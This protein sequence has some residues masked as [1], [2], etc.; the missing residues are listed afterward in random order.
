MAGPSATQLDLLAT[1]VSES[2]RRRT[3]QLAGSFAYQEG[4]RPKL[5]ELVGMGSVA[6]KLYL[7]LVMATRREPH[8]LYRGTSAARFARTLG[9]D[10]GELD[11]PRSAGTRRVQRAIHALHGKSFIVRTPRPGRVDQIEVRHFPVQEP[12]YVT[13]PLDLWRNGWICV[14]SVRALAVYVCLRRHC[15]GNEDEG[16]HVTP[17]VRRRAYQ[18]A[19]DTWTGG[20]EDLELAGLLTRTKGNPADRNAPS[21]R[22]SIYTLHSDRMARPPEAPSVASDRPEVPF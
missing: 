14:L 5:K 21:R 17:W 13:L 2:G 10:D 12:P 3:V 8:A 4:A 1:L 9:F 7:T 16:F 15:K 19:E 6:L 22:R 20:L 18:L 11:D